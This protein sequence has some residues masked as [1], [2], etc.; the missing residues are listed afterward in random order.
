MVLFPTEKKL[1]VGGPIQTAIQQPHQ[2]CKICKF[3]EYLWNVD[4]IHG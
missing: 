2:V 4:T 1:D 3:R